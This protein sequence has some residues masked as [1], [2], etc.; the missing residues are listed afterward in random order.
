MN[1]ATLMLDV[2]GGDLLNVDLWA[3]PW[4]V[5]LCVEMPWLRTV[6]AEWVANEGQ[7]RGYDGD[8]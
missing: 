7:D 4:W 8:G 2:V 5:K 6:A 1:V 3:T